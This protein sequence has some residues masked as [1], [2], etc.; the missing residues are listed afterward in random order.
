MRMRAV[1][2]L[3]PHISGMN[4]RGSSITNSTPAGGM[5]RHPPPSRSGER[6]SNSSSTGS[7][8][9][10]RSAER[11]SRVSTTPSNCSLASRACDKSSA[12]PVSGDRRIP[13]SACRS[14]RARRSVGLNSCETLARNSSR[15]RRDSSATTVCRSTSDSASDIRDTARRAR[16]ASCACVTAGP[17]G[18]S[19]RAGGSRCTALNLQQPRNRSGDAEHLWACQQWQRDQRPCAELMCASCQSLERRIGVDIGH[20]DNPPL[21]PRL[22]RWAP[23]QCESA[24][25]SA[26][27]RR[28]SGQ[29]QR[30]R[31]QRITIGFRQVHR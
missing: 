20:F 23:T 2:S 31:S 12:A 9:P 8:A 15:A 24:S 16:S 1:F 5:P 29:L 6:G 4:V 17:S 13:P 7:R 26:R 10:R 11:A 3:S 25:P 21:A 19:T 22:P 14:C 27:G 28:C 18:R 30:R